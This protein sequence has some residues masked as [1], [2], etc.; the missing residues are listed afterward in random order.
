MKLSGGA[1][2][3]KKAG[4][5]LIHTS[6]HQVRSIAAGSVL[7]GRNSAFA[8]SFLTRK[9]KLTGAACNATAILECRMCV[10]VALET[11]ASTT[12]KYVKSVACLAVELLGNIASRPRVFLHCMAQIVN[13][14]MLESLCT[15]SGIF[16]GIYGYAGKA[17]ERLHTCT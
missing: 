10:Y 6:P 3:D 16:D 12:T 2:V 4:A 14:E 8:E 9:E 13:S 15:R 7:A 5:A 17:F 1:N 11:Y